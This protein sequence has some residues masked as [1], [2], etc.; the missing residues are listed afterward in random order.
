MRSSGLKIDGPKNP[1]QR[2]TRR[3]IRRNDRRFFPLRL[4]PCFMRKR[5]ELIMQA[6]GCAELEALGAVSMRKVMFA[7]MQMMP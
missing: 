4:L 5:S 6:P 7:S 2:A 1:R 3:E